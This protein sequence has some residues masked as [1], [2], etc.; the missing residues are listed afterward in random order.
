MAT[1]S[2]LSGRGV[3]KPALQGGHGKAPVQGVKTTAIRDGDDY[4]INGSK[5]WT[6]LA[7]DA[8]HMFLL[9]RTSTE[10]RK[11]EGITFFILDFTTPGVT[12]R[13]IRTIRGD[14]EFAEEGVDVDALGTLGEVGW[15]FG[16]GE[17]SEGFDEAAESVEVFVA[18]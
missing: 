16:G 8:N 7:Q 18:G 1:K 9:A 10:G 6:S 17:F 13:P 2:P 12:V 3:P 5:I 11:Q 14:A 15:G 4:V